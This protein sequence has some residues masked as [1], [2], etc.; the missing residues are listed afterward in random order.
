MADKIAG[1]LFKISADTKALQMGM[2]KAQSAVGK[3]QGQMKAFGAT[4]LAAFSVRAV[5]SFLK[6]T[7]Q[8]YD[9]QAK[10]EAKLLTALKDKEDVQARLMR[11]ARALQGIT[12]FGD[13]ET[14]DA[15]SFLASMQLNE[16]AIRRL[17]P[18]VQD[19]ATSKNMALSA[20]ADLVAK[21]VGSSTNALSRY[22]IVI[23]GAV[24][25][26]ER[27]ESAVAALTEMFEG[28]AKA[29]AEA[30]TGAVKQL[31]NTWGDLKETI[32]KGISPALNEFAIVTNKFVQSINKLNERKVGKLIDYLS[33]A[34]FIGHRRQANQPP[35]T[36]SLGPRGSGITAR[37]VTAETPIPA[38]GRPDL[39]LA[40]MASIG[41]TSIGAAIPGEGINQLKQR[42]ES[43][44]NT[45]IDLGTVVQQTMMSVADSIGQG[46]ENLFAGT[47]DLENGLAGIAKVFGRF[48][49]QMGKLL[50]S[51][52][53]SMIAFK[54]AKL[55]PAAA[56]AAGAALL[57]IGSAIS[58]LASRGVSGGGGAIM[59]AGVAGSSGMSSRAIRVEGVLRGKDLYIAT[60]RGSSDMGSRT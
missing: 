39:S 47:S 20:A 30:G 46:I 45:M 51:Y 16:V 24:G 6:S 10:A 5:T 28:Q 35:A 2:K 36:T 37:A 21:S 29:A 8:L 7:V 40:P 18:L 13:E 27:L 60:Q 14:A 17:I 44:K 41:A 12:L 59:T 19:F 55:N 23:E 53:L 11:Q 57:A 9:V 58:G 26:S 50:I 43:I 48:A 52:G 49:Q 33:I 4:M 42:A 38:P 15:M 25:S 34:A 32:G 22:G 3:L 56:I 31:A 1:L 54:S